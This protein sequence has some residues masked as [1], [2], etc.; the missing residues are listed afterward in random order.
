MITRGFNCPG[1]HISATILCLL[2]GVIMLV[3][4][5]NPAWAQPLAAVVADHVAPP[6]APVQPLPYSHKTHLNSGLV[7]EL[8]HVNPDPGILMTFPPGETCVLCHQNKSG[9]RSIFLELQAYSDS[10]QEIPWK[11]VYTITPGV[12]WSHRAHL[13]AGVECGACHGEVSEMKIM[14]ESKATVAMASCI[15][16]HQASAAPVACVVCHAWPTD[17]DLGVD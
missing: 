17:H 13:E 9:D 10:A 1:K 3:L 8:C 11:R 7:C 14:Y 2:S 4:A 15:S 12:S 5:V 16:C 6:P